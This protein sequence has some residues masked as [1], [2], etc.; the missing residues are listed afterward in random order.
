MQKVPRFSH[1][2]QKDFVTALNVNVNQYF[3][4]NRLSR[5][6][7]PFMVFKSGV[8]L[9]LWLGSYSLLLLGAYDIP[10]M[11]M[12]WAILG[13]SLAMVTINIG[14][15]AIHGAYSRHKWV[16]NLLSHTFNLNGASA[17]MWVKMHNQA[18]HTYTNVDGFDEDIAPIPIIRIS[19]LKKRW[20]IHKY[21]YIYAFVLYGLTTLSWIF[22]KDYKKFF[23]NEVGNYS[24]KK[25]PTK[26][27]F[28][29]FFYKFI[30]YTLFLVIP[31]WVID[32]HWGYVLSGF[33]LMHFIGGW[34]LAI[35]FMLAHAV[36]ETHFPNPD[37]EGS[38]EHCWTVHQLYTTA[39]F[40]SRSKVLAFITGGLNTQIEHHLFPNICSVHYPALTV[41]VRETAQLHKIPYYESS[42][43]SALVSHQRFLW[44]MGN[45]D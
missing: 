45:Q 25:H 3:K 30:N 32:L 38:I 10:G 20:R 22:I 4:D 37:S 6:A 5:H 17:Y 7:T 14:H 21:Q 28:F 12:L 33:L 19:P 18:H 41:I 39:N 23:I 43:A 36:E 44:K 34:L 27:Y 35:I 8:Y 24:G 31:L 1:L 11:Y 13:V 29:L 42:L 15:D 16:N 26:E 40:S 2:N 9:S